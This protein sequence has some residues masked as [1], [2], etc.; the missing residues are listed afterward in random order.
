[1]FDRKKT[2]FVVLVLVILTFSFL[3]V[4]GSSKNSF[5][6]CAQSEASG[7]EPADTTFL[8]VGE[9]LTYAVSYSFFSIGTL[10]FKILDKGIRNGRPIFKA[11]AIIESNPSLS[12]LTEVHIRFYGEIDDSMFSHYWVSEDSSSSRIDYHT[13]TFNYSDSNLV[14]ERGFIYPDG[15]HDT[16]TI[17][18][19]TVTRPG[20]DGLS[21]FFYAREHARQKKQEVVPV[22]IDNKEKNAYINFQ[23]KIEEEEIDAV[24]YPI[25]TV[26]LD[27]HADFVGVVGMTGGFRGWF[28]NDAARIPI[29]ARL[30]VWLG[31][32]KVQLQSWKRPG[33]QPPRYI[34][35]R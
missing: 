34:E 12:W 15:K 1:M 13:L 30:N 31:S 17:D 23:D 9:E 29:L 10:S 35:P 25:E 33:W 22:F 27:G 4:G 5:L 3:F 26:F 8:Q 21:L 24:D 32:I 14:Y 19:I 18:T 16:A 7:P 11:K 2:T 6:R 20:Q 28:S